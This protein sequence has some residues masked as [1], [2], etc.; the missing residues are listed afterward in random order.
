MNEEIRNSGRSADGRFT[1]GNRGRVPG[2][3]HKATLAA[4]AILD[5][6]AEKLTRRAVEK[7]MEG[8]PV[9]MRLCLERIVPPARDRTLS[10]ALPKGETSIA[11]LTKELVELVTSG[12]I[13]PSEGETVASLIE[14]HI[15]VHEA[16]DIEARLRA[17]EEKIGNG[18]TR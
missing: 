16:S 10:F 13:S 18:T 2:S 6:D 14:K 8:D 12:N 9:A 11:E 5:G 17:L 15:R 7:A 4:Q 1:F 3:R